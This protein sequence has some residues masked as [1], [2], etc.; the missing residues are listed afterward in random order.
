L[1]RCGRQNGGPLLSLTH[2]LSSKVC[3][4]GSLLRHCLG[5]RWALMMSLQ[6]HLNSLKLRTKPREEL[7]KAKSLS[8]ALVVV[9]AP[10]STSIAKIS[11]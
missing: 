6:L 9:V 7:M 4:L 8:L 1:G 11:T 3:F 10:T 2:T 5:K